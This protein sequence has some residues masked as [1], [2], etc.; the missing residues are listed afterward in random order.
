MYYLFTHSWFEPGKM[1]KIKHWLILWMTGSILHKLWCSI[2]SFNNNAK[3]ITPI[4]YEINKIRL[5][6]DLFT[7]YGFEPYI[8]TRYNVYLV[9]RHHTWFHR[10]IRDKLTDNT[11]NTNHSWTKLFYNIQLLRDKH[12]NF[13]SSNESTQIAMLYKCCVFTG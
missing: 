9:V 7:H 4:N 5:C 12:N 11:L 10:K 3:M 2:V 1:C 13:R 6:I 8:W